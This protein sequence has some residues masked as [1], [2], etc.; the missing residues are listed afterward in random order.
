MLNNFDLVNFLE[1]ITLQKLFIVLFKKQLHSISLCRF[2]EGICDRKHTDSH[3][4]RS[5]EVPPSQILRNEFCPRDLHNGCINPSG[6]LRF[7]SLDT[8]FLWNTQL[9][10][11]RDSVQK[12]LCHHSFT[13]ITV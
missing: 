7:P 6:D 5:V 13:I 8:R 10:M 3:L 11:Y 12:I 1:T 4:N 9:F 2:L